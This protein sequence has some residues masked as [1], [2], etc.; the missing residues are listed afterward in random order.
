MQ[1]KSQ[2]TKLALMAHYVDQ[3]RERAGSRETVAVAI[4]ETHVAAGFN[5]RA[6]LH[7]DTQ[8][9][10]FTLAKN[11]ADRI[12]RWLDDKTK[13]GNFMPPNF[14]DSILLAMPEDLR[15][16][17][18]NEWLRLFGMAAKG[19]HDSSESAT[20]SQLLPGLIKESS[21]ATLALASLP[22]GCRTI[23]QMSR[24]ESLKY[25]EIA[26]RLGISIK[27]VENQMGKALKILRS[28]LKE[29]LPLVL[30]LWTFLHQ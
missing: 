23:F 9:D 8:G 30:A 3:W 26:D 24:F 13:D 4:V 7:F 12:F 5:T 21:E 20:P 11:A 2:K 28:K 17:Y 16:G 29:Y 27:T 22:E 14:E 25:Q 15:L 18:L 1:V 10:A 19:L 6:K